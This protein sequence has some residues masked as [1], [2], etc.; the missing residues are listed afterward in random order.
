MAVFNI[1]NWQRWSSGFDLSNNT[2]W[3]YSDSTTAIATI[4]AS[5]YFNSVNTN[6]SSPALNINDLIFV[7][8]SDAAEFIQVT[9]ISPAVTTTPFQITIGTGTVGTTNLANLGVTGAKI[10][11]ATITNDK[12]VAN[13]L[14][15]AS[16]ATDVIQYVKVPVTAVQ[17]NGAYAAPFV[18]I[19]APGANKLIRVHDVTLEVDYGSA[20][21]ANGG[22]LALQYD[23]TA[24]GAG[25]LASAALAAA[26]LN[27]FAAD[28]VV[29]LA[30]AAA[31]GAA[32]A[33]VNKGIYLS[34][35]TAAFDTGTGT[36]VD[37]HI[38]YSIVTT[39][40]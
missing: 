15:S 23:S 8:A 19:A 12:M 40:L 2:M 24:N 22:A 37:F 34:N 27:G 11:A 28:S 10:A 21:F 18:L 9:A 31:A 3:N 33:M 6:P 20:Q 36:T 17:L 14:T 1:N 16:I 35:L 7:E 25:V 4:T 32:S 26:T 29:G 30:G 13:T 39:T 38:S 5:G